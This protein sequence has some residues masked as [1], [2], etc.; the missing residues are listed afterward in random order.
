VPLKVAYEF[1]ALLI[2]ASIYDEAFSSLRDVLVSQNQDLANEM[3][4]YNCSSK[5]D[6]FHGI[7]FEGNRDTAQ[8]Q[9]RLFGLLAYTVRFPRIAINHPKAIY[10]HRLDIGEDQACVE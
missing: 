2:G 9:V 5:A 7:A 1:A 4:T 10:T 8:F 3:V 6:A